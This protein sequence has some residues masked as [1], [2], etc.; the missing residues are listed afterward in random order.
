MLTYAQ[1]EGLR[2]SLHTASNAAQRV[3][4][5]VD[6]IMPLLPPDAA[7]RLTVAMRGANK[8]LDEAKMQAAKAFE[9]HTEPVL[10]PMAVSDAAIEK[11]L[12]EVP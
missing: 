3:T 12:S 10:F 6:G 5:A 7:E 1:L 4:I 8:L 2:A 11:S 9:G